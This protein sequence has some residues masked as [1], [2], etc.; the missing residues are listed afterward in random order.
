M[1]VGA[2]GFEPP[3]SRSR[4]ERS[5]RLSHAPT[6]RRVYTGRFDGAMLIHVSTER[7]DGVRMTGI[8][9][10]G[11]TGSDAT[12]AVRPDRTTLAVGKALQEKKREADALV[13]LIEAAGASGKGQIVDYRA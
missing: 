1:L 13:R 5:T 8:P 7:A 9:S 10:L 6:T 3:T 2:R 11:T 4:T 12:V